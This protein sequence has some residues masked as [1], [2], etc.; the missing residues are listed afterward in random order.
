MDKMCVNQW[1]TVS[2]SLVVCSTSMLGI[3]YHLVYSGV[4]N[5]CSCVQY[6]STCIIRITELQSG[7]VEVVTVILQTFSLDLDRSLILST[8]HKLHLLLIIIFLLYFPFVI[9]TDS[10]IVT[11]HLLASG[12][13]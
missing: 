9:I 10:S 5:I 8:D 11:S 1:P 13:E 12:Q 2:L 7:K 4:T 6:C 3:C